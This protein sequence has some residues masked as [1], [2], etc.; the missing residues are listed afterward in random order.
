MQT[1]KSIASELRCSP[2]TLKSWQ[3]RLNLSFKKSSSGKY[4]NPEE[5]KRVFKNI[6]K[7]RGLGK[8]FE[9]IQQ[10][11]SNE[12]TEP[13]ISEKHSKVNFEHSK[14]D[15]NKLLTMH[16]DLMM[17]YSEANYKLGKLEQEVVQLKGELSVL[18]SQEE[19]MNLKKEL[20]DSQELNQVY[21]KQIEYLKHH[22]EEEQKK[23]W[24]K[25][26]LGL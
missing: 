3:T 5:V 23:G 13:V 17:S 7:W 10:I 9:T 16:N 18:P 8:G 15:P 25:R 1:I 20:A 26:L 14:I 11:I 24:F 2:N 6:K 12:I 21:Q 22:L 19:Y 4:N